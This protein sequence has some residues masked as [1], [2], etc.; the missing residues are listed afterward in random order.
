[1]GPSER[2]NY[3]EMYQ[4]PKKLPFGGF[5]YISLH[6]KELVNVLEKL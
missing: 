4:A 1:V 3:E 6:R 2:I 5:F